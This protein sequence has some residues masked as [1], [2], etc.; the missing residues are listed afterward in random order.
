MILFIQTILKF[1]LNFFYRPTVKDLLNH[2]FFQEDMGI[3]VELSN[4]E[5]SINSD[6]DKVLLRYCH[7]FYIFECEISLNIFLKITLPILKIN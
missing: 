2:E 3:K 4:K 7:L 6:S 5:E 1:S